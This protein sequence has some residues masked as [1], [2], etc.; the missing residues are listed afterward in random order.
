MKMID[1]YG[2][3]STMENVLALLPALRANHTRAPT[4]ANPYRNENGGKE[5]E[6]TD[7]H[8]GAGSGAVRFRLCAGGDRPAAGHNRQ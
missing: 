7:P 2:K 8:A 4:K 5:H 6:E 1:K 3:Q